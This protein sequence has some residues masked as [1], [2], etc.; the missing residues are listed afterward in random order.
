MARKARYVQSRHVSTRCYS[1]GVGTSTSQKQSWSPSI[2]C[3]YH[4]LYQLWQNP[5]CNRADSQLRLVTDDEQIVRWFLVNGAD[6]SISAIHREETHLSHPISHEPLSTMKPI[7]D[8]VGD[9]T[10][11]AL[12]HWST[13]QTDNCVDHFHYLPNKGAP[14]NITMWEDKPVLV[15]WATFGH[16]GT[17]LLNGVEAENLGLV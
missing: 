3:V 11:G 17:P 8:Q 4:L 6:P 9:I 14:F 15:H 7:F 2:W 1:T 10:K 13:D 12:L 5:I 16:V